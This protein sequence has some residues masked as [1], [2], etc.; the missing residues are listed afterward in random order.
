MN[1]GR[2]WFP[3]CVKFSLMARL[4]RDTFS[5]LKLREVF[6]EMV[7]SVSRSKFDVIF[8]DWMCKLFLIKNTCRE[9]E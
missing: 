7:L 3:G 1:G 4:C 9:K 6:L 2:L 8:M 5:H